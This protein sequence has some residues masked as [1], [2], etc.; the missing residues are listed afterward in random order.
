MQQL[1]KCKVIVSAKESEFTQQGYTPLPS[2]TNPITS[3][4][5]ALGSSIGKKKFGYKPFTAD[6][7]VHDF[8]LFTDYGLD[9]KMIETPGPQS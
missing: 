6:F 3:I 2:G 9:I 7:F 5:A 8:V 1:E 4:I